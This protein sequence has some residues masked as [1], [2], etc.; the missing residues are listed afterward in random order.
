[1]K[2]VV[3]SILAITLLLL[4]SSCG[5]VLKEDDEDNSIIL[6]G[7]PSKGSETDEPSDKKAEDESEHKSTIYPPSIF[8]I[9]ASGTCR[10]ELAP[11]YYADYECEFYADKLDETTNQ[12]ASGQYTG[13]FWMKTTIDTGEYLKELLKNV[14]V[15]MS[16]D[17]GGEGICDYIN[18]IVMNGFERESI[19][20][21]YVISDESGAE[22]TPSSD[23]LAARGSFTAELIDAYLDAKA[24]GAAG[25]K[26]E[27]NDNKG[28]STEIDFII[29]I[30]PD[31]DFTATKRKVKL[32]FSMSG[33]MQ[34][35]LEGVL[36]RLPGYSEDL[37]AYTS[38]GKREAILNKHL[39]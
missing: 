17:A 35:T 26:L 30:E 2:K 22:I 34:I 5:I 32:Y 15:E 23:T 9:E 33:G 6:P 11:G 29:H 36:H 20:G 39:E 19:G 16:F 1:M 18:V 24:Q 14:P 25:E 21:N 8:A 10:Q 13:V 27:H 38:Q 7:G 31:P 12:S 3:L 28:E 37:K 4:L